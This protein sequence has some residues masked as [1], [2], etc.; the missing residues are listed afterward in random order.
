MRASIHEKL[1]KAG[2]M[3][4]GR[5]C[6]CLFLLGA[7]CR[8][9]VGTNAV[10]A[11][12]SQRKRP[13]LA[14]QSLGQNFLQDA[15]L[16]SAIVDAFAVGAAD[17][18]GVVELGPGQGALTSHALRRWPEMVAV[19]LDRRAISTLSEAMP[20]LSIHHGDM[21]RVD[22]EGLCLARGGGRLAVLSNPPYY[23]TSDLLMSL[24]MNSAHISCAVLTLQKEAVERL[25]SPPRTK[26]YTALGVLYALCTTTEVLF[27]LPPQAFSPAPS[28][29]SRCIRIGFKPPDEVGDVDAINMVAR[30]AF[31]DRRKM[32]RQSLKRLLSTLPLDA[33]GQR[34]QVPERFAALRAEELQPEHFSELASE[35]GLARLTG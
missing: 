4:A 20:S 24:V 30:A 8:R 28:V 18:A 6:A 9:L 19:E 21:L 3:A 1:E 33:T 32:L 35:L 7:T 15:S 26:G 11:A 22:W 5:R 34:R 2:T 29:T 27:D 10:S 31:G 16:A 13:W 23:L 17:C 25:L 12:S 14:K